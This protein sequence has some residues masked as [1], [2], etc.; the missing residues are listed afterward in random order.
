M[1]VTV[2]E[3]NLPERAGRGALLV[4]RLAADAA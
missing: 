4:D 3:Y 1:M 2:P